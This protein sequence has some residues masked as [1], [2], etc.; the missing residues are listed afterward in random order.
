[1]LS[2]RYYI[3][4]IFNIANIAVSQSQNTDTLSLNNNWKF[5]EK[6]QQNYY[7]AQVPGCIHN[8]LLSNKLIPEPFYTCNEKDLQWIETKTWTYSATFKVDEKLLQQQHIHLIAEGLDT[9]A[10]VFI[11]DKLAIDADN[12]FRLWRK[13]VK[14]LLHQGENKIEIV[15]EPAVTKGKELASK[16]H[17]TLPGDEKVFVRKAQYQFGWDWGPRFVTCGIWQPIYLISWN[18]CSLEDVQFIQHSLNKKEAKIGFA[19]RLYTDISQEFTIKISDATTKAV[20]TTQ[21]LKVY[22]GISTSEIDF[23]I[24]NPILWWTHDL[25]EPHLY[26]FIVEVF[27]KDKCVGKR[28]MNVGL[29]TIEVV[30]EK[31]RDG[32]SFYFKLNGIP[33]FMKGANYI[34]QD[35]FMSRVTADKYNDL[36]NIAVSNN[37]NML[38]VWGGGNY[39]KDIFYNLCDA[40][41]ILVWQDFMFACA[42]YPGDDAFQDNC[43]REIDY[44]VKRLRNHPCIALWCGNNEM[45]EGW[46]NWEWQKQYH[47]SLADS[48]EIWYNYQKLF[49]Q[50]IPDIIK[51]NDPDRFYWSSSPKY[52]WGREE[53]YSKGDSHYWGVW[54]GMEPFDI[55]KKKVG[56]FVSE[57]GFQG[58]PDRITLGKVIDTNEL[59][60]NSDQMKCHEKH[61][62]GFETIKTYMER[63]YKVPTNLDDYIYTSQ[64]LQAYGIKTAIEA[65]R[66]AKPRCMGTLY[67]QLNDCWP[68]V[69][70]SGVDYY[71][72]PKAL[73]YF[74]KKAYNDILVTLEQNGNDIEVRVNSDKM[75]TI[76]AEL[77]LQLWDFNGIQIT[78]QMKKITLNPNNNTFLYKVDK[79]NLP[80]DSSLSKH[81]FLYACINTNDTIVS[82]N[83]LYFN[84][85]KDLALLNPEI[86]WRIDSLQGKFSIVLYGKKLAKNVFIRFDNSEVGEIAL[87]DNYFDLLPFTPKQIFITS[88]QALETIK[89]HIRITSLFDIK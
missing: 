12:M 73:Q 7:P 42:M 70:W 81:Q 63:E 88:K 4:L 84:N 10:K 39:E 53:S 19:S 65:H 48:A 78:N 33:V 74:V 72:K 29:R 68:V 62:T 27:L 55:Y 56:R 60:L 76:N 59:R 86:T 2:I 61:P 38:R 13:D 31:D 52:G 1:M 15:F 9:Y 24:R 77:L 45:D 82:E 83:F 30:N 50:I 47:Y 43:S 69:S 67:W 79:K 49:H 41:G 5:A 8:D 17:Y 89:S 28:A 87:S 25:G 22:K 54:W 34:P 58:F 11:N 20:Y 80:Y 35:N 16:L 71:H 14:N 21:T 26:H 18:D 85:P 66:N 32:E 64:L 36:L 51:T 40:K 46:K 44:Q 57:Y 6:G 23:T 37:M 3:L 75:E